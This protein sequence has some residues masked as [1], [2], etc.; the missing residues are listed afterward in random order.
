ML[1]ITLKRLTALAVLTIIPATGLV[2][3]A[4]TRM[5]N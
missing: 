4:L 2:T 3:A 1:T 5:P